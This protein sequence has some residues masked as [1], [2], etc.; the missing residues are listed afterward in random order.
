MTNISKIQTRDDL[1]EYIASLVDELET[2]SVDWKNITLASYLESLSAY[3]HDIDGFYS[4]MG[5]DVDPDV[6]TWGLIADV[7]AGARVYD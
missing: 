6:C 4:N 2:G 7:F 3:L 1:V 5:M